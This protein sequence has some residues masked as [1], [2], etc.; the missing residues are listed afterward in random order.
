[1]KLLERIWWP[2]SGAGPVLVPLSKEMRDLGR[3]KIIHEQWRC[4][5]QA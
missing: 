1:M 2:V 5:G 4:N 3:F